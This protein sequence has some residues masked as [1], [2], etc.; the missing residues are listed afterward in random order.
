M[1]DLEKIRKN[2]LCVGAVVWCL[3]TLNIFKVP[4]CVGPVVCGAF[5]NFQS[6]PVCGPCAVDFA[7]KKLSPWCVG[8]SIRLSLKIAVWPYKKK[9]L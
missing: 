6:S 5:E 3:E 1:G 9:T 2:S 7:K 4:L 8:N